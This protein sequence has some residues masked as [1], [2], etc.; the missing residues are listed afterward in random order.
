M[1]KI[2]EKR[3]A[4]RHLIKGPIVLYSNIMTSREIDAH[5]L[6]FSDNGI[7]FTTNRKLVP[8]TTIFL[9]TSNECHVGSEN[10]DDCQLRS[11]SMVTV[12]WCHENP[13]DEKPLYTVG[14]TYMLDY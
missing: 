4:S 13:G 11:I 9:R 8:G 7:C 10:H 5:L 1:A 14:A 3:V 2:I 6:N 12:K